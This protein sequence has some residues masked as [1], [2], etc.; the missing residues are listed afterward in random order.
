MEPIQIVL[1][2]IMLIVNVETEKRQY[3][4]IEEQKTIIEE[5]QKKIAQMDADYIKL[6][7]AHSS[8]YA[9]D[10]LTNEEFDAKIT[11]ILNHLT[12]QYKQNQ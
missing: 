11:F 2:F 9:N 6:A 7:I 10:K 12:E 4:I 1:G 5:Q 3:A 8:L